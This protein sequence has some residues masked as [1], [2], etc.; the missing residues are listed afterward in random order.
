MRFALAIAIALVATGCGGPPEEELDGGAGAEMEGPPPEV[1]L[2]A[3]GLQL[4]NCPPGPA[5]VGGVYAVRFETVDTVSHGDDVA[6]QEQRVTRYGVA[7]FCVEQRDIVVELLVCNMAI[8]P[9]LHGP[10]NTCAAEAPTVA[11][12][13]ALPVVRFAGE[14]DLNGGTV[15][16]T[17]WSERWGLVD[18]ASLPGEPS[19]IDQLDA[20]D[21][22]AAGVLYQD[23]DKQV[24]VTLEGTGAVPTRTFVAR[25]TSADFQLLA[26]RLDL[27]GTSTSTTEQVVLGGPATRLVRGRTRVAASGNAG[28]LRAD[29][30]NGA[31][32]IGVGDGV[33]QCAEMVR[34]VNTPLA[35]PADGACVLD[36]DEDE[37]G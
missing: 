17:G 23:G 8:G 26:S 24:G 12:L 14:I 29:G 5:D 30:L 28:F 31:D 36:E 16:L 35:P 1:V 32:D 19:G 20:A 11:L 9:V 33:V 3:K 6:A 15:N 13:A 22:E 34:W 10:S 7:Q 18:G 2:A 21:A 37:E 25:I 4:R 27:T